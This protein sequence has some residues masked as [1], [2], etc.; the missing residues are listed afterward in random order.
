M[1]D[2]RH[3]GPSLWLELALRAVPNALLPHNTAS[4]YCHS[5]VLHWGAVCTASMCCHKLLYYAQRLVC[6]CQNVTLC[7]LPQ[8]TAC[9]CCCKVLM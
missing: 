8:V 3:N 7:W 6:A 2:V 1:S 9:V 4:M 5:V